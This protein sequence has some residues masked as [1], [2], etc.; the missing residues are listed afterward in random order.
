MHE[1]AWGGDVG[2]GDGTV[3]VD[4]LKEGIEVCAVV[5]S[6]HF[7]AMTDDNVGSDELFVIGN[8]VRSAN[9]DG[10]C[11]DNVVEIFSTEELEDGCN[12]VGV[13]RD[14]VHL[15]LSYDHFVVD[16][17]HEWDTEISFATLSA[18]SEEIRCLCDECFE[19]LC[20]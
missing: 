2:S 10:I 13:A 6:E 11:G 19:I 20:F 17:G 16:A 9:D 7:V 18:G 15:L 8:I 3:D 1:L 4:G 5:R 14:D 12:S